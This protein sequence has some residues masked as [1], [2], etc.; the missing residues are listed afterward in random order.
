MDAGHVRAGIEYSNCF[1]FTVTPLF[2]FSPRPLQV[3]LDESIV[4][5][6][7]PEGQQVDLCVRWLLRGF[8]QVR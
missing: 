5:R 4:P 6:M 3:I 8:R 1:A 2:P 7:E